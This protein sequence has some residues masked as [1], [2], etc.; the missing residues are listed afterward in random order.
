VVFP[1]FRVALDLKRT[2]SEIE[3]WFRRV[4]GRQVKGSTDE[5]MKNVFGNVFMLKAVSK[6]HNIRI[7]AKDMTIMSLWVVGLLFQSFFSL[8]AFG[9]QPVCL[10]NSAPSPMSLSCKRQVWFISLTWLLRSVMFLSQKPLGERR[11]RT[12]AIHKTF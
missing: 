7:S 4:V 9:H 10:Q 1:P 11:K 8:R 3:V 12:L 6:L 2:L 5:I